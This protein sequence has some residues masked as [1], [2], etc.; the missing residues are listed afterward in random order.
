MSLVTV[1]RTHSMDDPYITD[2][3]S[4]FKFQTADLSVQNGFHLKT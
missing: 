4:I 1:L 3:F 2:R